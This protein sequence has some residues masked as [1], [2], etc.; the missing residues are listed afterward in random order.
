[1]KKQPEFIKVYSATQS[2]PPEE[3]WEGY[4]ALIKILVYEYK[5]ELENG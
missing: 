3:F 2:P 5:K 1:M 4:K